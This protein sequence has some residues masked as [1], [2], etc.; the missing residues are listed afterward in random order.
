[1]TIYAENTIDPLTSLLEEGDQREIRS[2]ITRMIDFL[3]L[4]G[5]TS[6]FTNL[7]SPA[8]Q[9]DTSGETEVSSLIANKEKEDW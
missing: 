3:K 7:V 2:M 8:A 1:M 6:F 4:N 9:N 5:I